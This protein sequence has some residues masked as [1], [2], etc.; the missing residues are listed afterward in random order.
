MKAKQFKVVRSRVSPG[1]RNWKET[2]KKATAGSDRNEPKVSPLHPT[3]LPNIE[4][5]YT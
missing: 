4:Y 5:I 1:G 2:L 3:V